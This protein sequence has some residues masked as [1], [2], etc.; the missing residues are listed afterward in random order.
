MGRNATCRACILHKGAKHVCVWG[1]GL[2]TAKIMLVGEAPGAEEDQ[3]GIPF[4][5]RAGSKLNDLLTRAG[6]TRQDVYISN[7]VKCFISPRVTTDEHQNACFPYLLEEIDTVQPAVIVALGASPLKAFTG[8][9][10]IG[11]ARGRVLSVL[12]RFRFSDSVKFMAT[13]HPAALLHQFSQTIEDNI[14]ADLALAKSLADNHFVSL[15]TDADTHI[16]IPPFSE[17]ELIEALNS[18]GTSPLT[19]DSEWSALPSSQKMTWPWDKG[20]ELFSLAFG[21][22][23]RHPTV[24]SFAYQ[25]AKQYP[26]FWD[27]M[28][29]RRPLIF[30]NSP[31]DLTWF[32]TEGLPYRLGGDT[33]F[34][35]YLRDEEQRLKL[36]ILAPKYGVQPGWKVDE[37]WATAP[38]TNEGWHRL[39][40]YNAEDVFATSI[41]YLGQL[42][43]YENLP[44]DERIRLKRLYS[45]LILPAVPLVV[46]MAI[47]GMPL[48]T[49]LI[50]KGLNNCEEKEAQF[51]AQFAQRFELGASDSRAILGSPAKASAFLLRQ[52]TSQRSTNKIEM[53][54]SSDPLVAEIG[55]YLKEYRSNTKLKGT[56]FEPW[57]SM[58]ARQNDERLHS[59]YRLGA[60]EVSTV[61]T[62]RTSAE[63]EEGG[64]I[65]VAPRDIAIRSV[66]K[67]KTGR[68]I[69]V[70]DAS[71]IEL[72]VGGAWF[73]GDKRMRDVYQ[74]GDKVLSDLHSATAAYLHYAIKEGISVEHFWPDRAQYIA[75]L[76]KK[77]RQ[78]AKSINFGFLYG[79]QVDNFVLYAKMQYGLELTLAQAHEARNGYFRLYPD[80]LEWHR[81]SQKIV[82]QGFVVTPFG[83]YRRNIRDLTKALN[84]P[85][86]GTASDL[87]LLA[88]IAARKE[89]RGSS[90]KFN[91]FPLLCGFIHDSI[92]AE[93]EDD[94]AEEVARILCYHMEHPPTQELFGFTMPVL[95]R[96]DYT[97]SQA[98]E[99]E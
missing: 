35:E 65:Q 71:Q 23:E 68:S 82:E 42:K 94:E 63:T 93:A 38:T 48:D 8:K 75:R 66:V 62:G 59:M 18:L 84:T 32:H 97:I 41:T 90:A 29:E 19:C 2:T 79:L 10:K 83:R 77:Q 54:K 99:Q 30:H 37:Y 91:M 36:D 44:E 17:R 80:L 27:W 87:I 96:A 72:R 56:Y 5:G 47:N 89:L 61:R 21:T 50:R 16:L 45:N 3:T 26:A 73:A 52:G 58:L 34:L 88:A 95:L 78:D 20:A 51:I 86:Q 69:I 14:V 39:L 22:L 70:C 15:T 57:L 25:Q 76:S 4:M 9:T 12:P 24:V 46:D 98:W 13:Y 40:F 1:T 28:A 31:A 33:L 74:T 55:K 67:A 60:S 53:A 6:L 11:E 7:V 85:V 64:S 92:E 49:D 81:R 43:V